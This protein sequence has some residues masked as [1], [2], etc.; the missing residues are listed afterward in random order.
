MRLVLFLFFSLLTLSSA[1]AQGV[2]IGSNNAPDSAAVLDLQGTQGGLLLPRLTTVQ[3]NALPSPPPGLQVYNIDNDCVELFFANGGWK[4]LTC[5]CNAF[6][7]AVFSLP[8]A[9]V[10]STVSFAAPQPNATYAWLFQNGSPAS[11]NLANP[12]VTWSGS[13]T[14]AVSLTVTDSA[15][16]SSSHTDSLTVQNC[17]PQQYTFTTCGKT[18]SAGPSQSQCNSTY[19]PG[20]VTVS[21]GIQAWTVPASGN[22]TIEARGARGGPAQYGFQ[23]GSGAIIQGTFSLTAG[24]VLN[25]V[26]G[27]QGL[28]SPH[29][30]YAGGGGGGGSFVYNQSTANLLLAAG[31]GGGASGRTQGPAGGNAQTG[32]TGGSAIPHPSQTSTPAA[33]GG[34]GGTGGQNGQGS[35]SVDGAGGGGFTGDGQGITGG[36]AFLNG[37]LGG[38]SNNGSGDGGFGG[39]G[40]SGLN[41]SG[42][43]GGGGG[44]YSGGGGGANSGSA[45]FGQGGGGGASFNGGT[46]PSSSV[47][48]NGPGTIIITRIC[49]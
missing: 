40:A 11:S 3:R 34:S 42:Y 5:G 31:G 28:Q 17:S 10:N 44:G 19:G 37:A 18:G 46:N 48:N 4:P 16:C 25:L 27:Q 47:S 9:S 29:Q 33:P 36:D 2:T 39:G 12:S 49:P 30:T 6:P 45:S 24:Q 32:T 26:V 8:S 21:N 38:S 1:S 15:G 13:G 22:Y 35:S 14:Y 41:G 43:H 7:N 23:G 20:I